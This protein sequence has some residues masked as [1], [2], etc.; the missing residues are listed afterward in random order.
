MNPEPPVTR[1]F[2]EEGL[3]GWIISLQHLLH[4]FLQRGHVVL[5]GFHEGELVAAAVE[6]VV[7]VMGLEIDITLE[8]VG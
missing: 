5:D 1:I 2:M 8:I 4:D 6:V 7:R 3:T